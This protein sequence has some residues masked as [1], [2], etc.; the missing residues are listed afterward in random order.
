MSDSV[1]VKYTPDV[2]IIGGIVPDSHGF[3]EIKSYH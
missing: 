1:V 2:I 3:S